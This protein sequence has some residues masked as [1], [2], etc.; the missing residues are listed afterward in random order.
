MKKQKKQRGSILLVVMILI[1][2]LA[3]LI[4]VTTT[5]SIQNSKSQI[6]NMDKNQKYYIALSGANMVFAALTEGGSASILESHTGVDSGLT[7]TKSTPDDKDSKEIKCIKDVMTEKKNMAIKDNKDVVKGYADVNVDLIS[8]DKT[9]EGTNVTYSNY[10][11][12]IYSRGSVDKDDKDK[13][14]V[15]MFVFKNDPMNTLVFDGKR[16]R[17]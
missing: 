14:I 2:I 10:I 5:I 1:V 6:Q 15:T 16:I 11:Y 4:F 8:L 13:R 3:F 17:P 12:R 7:I 9:T